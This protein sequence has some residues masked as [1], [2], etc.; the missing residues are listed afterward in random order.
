MAGLGLPAGV[1]LQ[2]ESVFSERTLV[3]TDHPDIEIR[4]NVSGQVAIYS[5]L[6]AL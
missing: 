1:W 6:D 5:G 3:Q 4:G 2:D